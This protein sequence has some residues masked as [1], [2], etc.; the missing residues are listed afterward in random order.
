[1]ARKNSRWGHL[2]M[3]AGTTGGQQQQEARG[4]QQRPDKLKPPYPEPHCSAAECCDC[5]T[6]SECDN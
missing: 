6:P 4:I 2:L 1:M 5:W 3:T